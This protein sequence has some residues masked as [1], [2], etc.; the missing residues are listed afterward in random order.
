MIRKQSVQPPTK[1]DKQAGQK[2]VNKHLEALTRSIEMSAAK[3]KNVRKPSGNAKEAVTLRLSKECLIEFRSA[4]K[5]GWRLKMQ[6]VLE[7]WEKY[8]DE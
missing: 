7:A 4:F 6:S 1:L 2:L 3:N 8:G 5:D